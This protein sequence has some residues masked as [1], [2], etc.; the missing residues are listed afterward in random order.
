M[1]RLLGLAVVAAVLAGC[2]PG[3]KLKSHILRDDEFL[4]TDARLR[5]VTNTAPGAFS[6][7]GLV[8]PH[9]IVC[10]EPSPDVAAAIATSFLFLSISAQPAPT[11]LLSLRSKPSTN[12]TSA[13]AAADSSSAPSA[14]PIE[15]I[16][17]FSASCRFCC[18][19]DCRPH[20]DL[21]HRSRDAICNRGM[22][23]CLSKSKRC[24][25]R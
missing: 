22:P 2:A 8:D 23:V 9:K 13:D 18:G 3:A 6:R 15:W 5:V 16:L 20:D 11:V 25:N 4:A 12:R 17:M 24:A 10:T 1:K 14:M 21:G 19:N 7:P